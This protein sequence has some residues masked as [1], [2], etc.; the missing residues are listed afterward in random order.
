MI[1]TISS[2]GQVTLPKK[3]RTRLGVAPGDKLQ[4]DL[5]QPGKAVIEPQKTI[6]DYFGKLDGVW[7]P[8]DEDPAKTIRAW[9]DM[10]D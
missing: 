8:V 2:K 4:V 5:S 7:G 3:L 10:D 9:R 6:V 1:M